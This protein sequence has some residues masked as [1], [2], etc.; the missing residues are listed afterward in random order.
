MKHQVCSEAHGMTQCLYNVPPRAWKDYDKSWTKD[1][2]RSKVGFG[3]GAIDK[4]L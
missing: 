4:S 1:F 2:V 3:Y